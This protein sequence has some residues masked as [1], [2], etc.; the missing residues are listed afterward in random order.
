MKTLKAMCAATILVLSLSIPTSAGDSHSPG[1]NP[2]APEGIALPVAA[3]G[4]PEATGTA[5][6][7][8]NG[9]SFLTLVDIMWALASIY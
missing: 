5:S 2:P 9:R 8:D 4:S 7:V 1:K 6:A 3:P